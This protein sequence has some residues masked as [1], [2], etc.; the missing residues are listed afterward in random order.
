[1]WRAIFSLVLLFAAALAPGTAG[2]AARL[3]YR[4]SVLPLGQ[5]Q[6]LASAWLRAPGDSVAASVAL[7][8]IVG[9][10]QDLGY[11]DARA[12]GWRDTLD[13]DRVRLE[14]N[15][16]AR[17]R[18]RAVQIRAASPEDSAA[19]RSALP[20]AAGA[21]ASPPGVNQ[22]IE[23]ALGQIADHGYP[24]AQLT[25][26]AWDADS[27]GVRL[28]LEAVRG[29]QVT[30]TAIQI[31]GLHV[32]RPAFAGR[33]LAGMVGHPFQRATAEAGRDRLA[34]LGLFRE[35]TYRGLVGEGDWHHA[36]LLYRV[37]EP[38][39]NRF[40][41]AL[42]VQGQA[43]TVGL[44]NL[45]LGNLLG[46]GRV[47]GLRWEARGR[48]LSD[49]SAR[50]LEPL[51]LGT[52]LQLEGQVN[53]QVQDTLFTRTRWG[54]RGGF[55]LSAQERLE[56]GYEQERVV[57]SSGE[58]EEASLQNTVFSL[59]RN[60]LD[61]PL[62]PRRGTLARISA[63]QS[64]KRERLRPADTRTARASAVE[65]RLELHRPISSSAGLSL[66][67]SGAGRFSSERVLPLFERYPLGGAATLRGFD[68]ESFRV[69]RYG[70]SRLEWRWFL[71]R[72]GQRTALFWDHAWTGTR[73]ANPGGG[74]RFE[75][76][77]HD[78]VGFGLRLEAAGG[79][80]GV[81]YGLEPGRGAL[82]GKIHLQ[83]VSTF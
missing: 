59:E 38:R 52:P 79:L 67:L 4:G 60:A 25:V 16:G 44:A 70:L 55:A 74:D 68:E 43:G 72:G 48:G 76:Q 31:D 40:E 39:Y 5:V 61:E 10:L 82:E 37:E 53:Q 26:A 78:G 45:Q 56:V 47:V 77:H 63:S 2:A 17:R 30:V 15:E 14:V 81:D 75:Q 50:Y 42:G 57:Q 49:F 8:R 22:A 1:M 11:L 36:R 9:R 83:L 34:Q 65:A 33:P 21:W 62:S 71:G 35:V 20:L 73:L 80:I 54:G 28:A 58:V 32:T 51:V 64:F 18:L 3:D 41:G 12:R 46:T 7:G 66:E 23:S 29:P 19:V 27:G 6:S 69:D 24:Y 13:G